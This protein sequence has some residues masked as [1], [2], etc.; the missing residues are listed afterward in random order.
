MLPPRLHLSSHGGTLQT[1]SFFLRDGRQAMQR[2][3]SGC[4]RWQCN[5]CTADVLYGCALWLCSVTVVV[6]RLPL[7][8]RHGR[9]L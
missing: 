8:I 5:G 1:S 7:H 6:E 4:A 9:C 3:C 2:V